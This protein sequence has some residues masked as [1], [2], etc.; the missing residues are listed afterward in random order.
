[1]EGGNQRRQL[2]LLDVLKL[3]DEEDDGGSRL[4]CRF[5]NYLDERLK[6]VFQVSAVGKSW[7]RVEIEANLDVSMFDLQPFG[8]PGKTSER[9][10]GD[11]LGSI[12]SG[13]PEKRDAQ[14]RGEHSGK[15]PTLRCLD[16]DRGKPHLLR[17]LPHAI[18]ENGLPDA[19]QSDEEH[20]L[21][22]PAQPNALEGDVD[23]LAEGV[24][25]GQL[26]RWGSGSWCEGIVDS[27]HRG[28][29]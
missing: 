25:A 5:A 26:G 13:D 4:S 1:M 18:Q 9:S 12:V 27:I 22:G 14:F 20:T 3:V 19:A 29:L 2:I 15:G 8:K 24:A 21:C 23:G 11:I 6:I 28:S 17:V 16:R 7:L 10:N